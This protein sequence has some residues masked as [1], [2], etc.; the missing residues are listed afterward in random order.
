MSYDEERQAHLDHKYRYDDRNRP[1]NEF[2]DCKDCGGSGRAECDCEL[3][4][5]IECP[6]CD[7][8]GEV[9]I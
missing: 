9:E 8:M 4:H 7:G 3:D 1:Q 6:K 5:V 2:V